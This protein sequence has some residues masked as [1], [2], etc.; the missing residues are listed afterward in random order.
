MV[1]TTCQ[2][3]IHSKK[4]RGRV[5]LEKGTLTLGME[6]PAL[7]MEI[8]LFDNDC[9]I[10]V[11]PTAGRMSDCPKLVEGEEGGV[12]NDA[13]PIKREEVNGYE[14][15]GLEKQSRKSSDA[16]IGCHGGRAGGGR[17]ENM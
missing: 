6:S 7:K 8:P 14:S 16:R 15:I 4:V 2:F 10:M 1:V 3:P 5:V 9:D 13:A 12:D 11:D 17:I